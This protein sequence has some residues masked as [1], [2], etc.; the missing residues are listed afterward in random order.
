MLFKSDNTGR[1]FAPGVITRLPAIHDRTLKF[2]K[3]PNGRTLECHIKANDNELIILAAHWTSRLEAHG[4]KSEHP[5]AD[6]RMSYAHDCYGRFRAILESNHDADV[7]LC[8]D[9][10]DE[11]SD[12]SIREGLHA[13]GDEDEVK[14]VTES[15]TPLDLFAHW[16]GEPPGTISYHKHWSLFD[17]IC[18]SR[19]LLDDKGWSCNPKTAA[20]YAPKWMFR[21]N[22]PFR[23]GE[24]KAAERG[25]S[26][27]FPVTVELRL[28]GD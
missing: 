5:H 13:S 23:F 3:N 4:G 27:H 18:V 9:F 7:I 1:R 2:A 24:A 21:A 28:Q 26:D 17:H 22:E 15:P 25:Y 10:N 14:N 8:G 12:P 6:R 19:G 16:A 20:I 11:F